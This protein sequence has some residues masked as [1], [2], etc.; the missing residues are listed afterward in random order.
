ML[1]QQALISARPSTWIATLSTVCAVHCVAAPM[2]VSTLPVFTAMH[3]FEGW[4]VGASA[5][6]A[7]GSLSASWRLHRCPLAWGG[8]AA[9][10]TIWSLS[11]AGWL[12]PLPE[13]ATS[14]LGGL[15]IAI[16]LFRNGRLRHQAECGPCPCPA[17][18]D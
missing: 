11:V 3:A 2:L 1:E 12:A 17:H 18:E 4:L 13:S 8:A 6:V 15:L 14:L 7:T 5:L 16:A 10:V 9:G